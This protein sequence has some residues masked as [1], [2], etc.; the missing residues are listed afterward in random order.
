[1]RGV[2]RAFNIAL[3]VVL[4]GVVSS[5]PLRRGESPWAKQGLQI[6]RRGTRA[7]LVALIVVSIGLVWVLAAVMS[8]LPL[9]KA[10]GSIGDFFMRTRVGRI[11]TS[12]I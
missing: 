11:P 10:A 7:G 4:G 12:A 8:E 1:M 2:P 9:E 6:V 3:A 5:E